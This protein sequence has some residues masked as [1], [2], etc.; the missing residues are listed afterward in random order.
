MRYC[1]VIELWCFVLFRFFKDDHGHTTLKYKNWS[2]DPEWQPGPEMDQIEIF[3]LDDNRNQ[4]YPT[5]QPGLVEPDFQRKNSLN[6]VARNINKLKLYLNYSQ[7]TWWQNFLE[8]PCHYIELE[9]TSSHNFHF[10]F[11]KSTSATSLN[12]SASTGSSHQQCNSSP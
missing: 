1:I 12:G 4:I 3:H 2:S 10:N 8:D 6:D 11:L 7:F 5:G 9:G